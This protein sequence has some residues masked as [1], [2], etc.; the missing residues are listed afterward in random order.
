VAELDFEEIGKYI[1]LMCYHHGNDPLSEKLIEKQVGSLSKETRACFETNQ[2]G[3]LF[4]KWLESSKDER[5][6]SGEKQRQ[7]A[8]SRWDKV[9]AE[10]NKKEQTNNNSGTSSAYAAALPSTKDRDRDGDG[11]KDINTVE[12]YPSFQEFW[13]LYYKKTGNKTLIKPKFDKLPQKV[14]K[15]ILNYLPAYIES[16]P[17][18][19]YRKNPQTFLDNKAWEDELIKY[20]SNGRQQNNQ[21]DYSNLER[22]LANT[23]GL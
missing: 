8:N 20:N 14:K 10:K 15:E 21:P 18:K 6:S 23:E 7:R 2:E 13:D 3:K 9:R 22:I 19:T 11:D 17:D 4:L 5:K 16:T 12:V 1:T